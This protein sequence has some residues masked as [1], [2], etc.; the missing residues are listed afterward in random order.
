[1]R[2]CAGARTRAGSCITLLLL[3]ANVFALPSSTAPEKTAVRQIPLTDH[4]FASSSINVVAGSRQ[5]LFTDNGHQYAGFYD[6]KGRVLLAKRRLPDDKWEIHATDFSTTPEDAHNTIS[7]VVDGSGY[8]HLA[9]GHH[10]SPLSY[11]RSLAPGSLAMEKPSAMVGTAESS[12]TYPQFFRQE[13]GD[14]LFLY[15]DGGSGNGRLVLNHYDTERRK[16]SRRQ[17]N[18]ID[19]EQQ[20][21]AYWD[22]NIDGNGRLH[23]AWNW[24]E[25]PDVAT[26][27]SLLYA[28]SDDGGLTWVR[29]DGSRYA[30]P[31]TQKTAEVAAAIPQRSNLMNPPFIATDQ[32]G[33]PVIA[34][35]WSPRE[36]ATPRFN[37]VYWEHNKWHKVAGPESGIHFTLQGHGTKRPPMSRAVL[38]AGQGKD[39]ERVHLIYRDDSR[40]GRVVAA[41][42][43]NLHA[44]AW[45]FRFL[46]DTDVGAWEPSIDPAQWR[47]TQ[48]VHL[49]LQAVNQLDG[50]DA[51]GKGNKPTPLSVL[52][53]DPTKK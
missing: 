28:R 10:N 14:L 9:W 47:Q 33:R 27:H 51:G 17:D 37:L 20:R 43:E 13:N 35:Y 31:I 24:R 36:G 11:S 4:A 49:L 53:W 50:D 12:V 34:S 5:T 19:G 42:L 3:A 40:N 41:S 6:A 25:T 21:S 29:T 46:T 15:R 18:L 48:Q 2:Q 16:W 52:V 32:R 38:I 39:S 30:L 7:L 23:L 44:R 1:M 45:Q 8:L 22:M 26:N